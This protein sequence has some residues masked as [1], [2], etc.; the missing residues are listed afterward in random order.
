M[1]T[2]SEKYFRIF[3]FDIIAAHAAVYEFDNVIFD[4]ANDKTLHIII[5]EDK[6]KCST[7]SS[8]FLDMI[9]LFET[10]PGSIW[11]IL[12][13]IADKDAFRTEQSS[14]VFPMP[15]ITI[16]D[17]CDIGYSFNYLDILLGEIANL[18]KI[19][20]LFSSPFM[21]KNFKE[22]FQGYRNVIKTLGQT[23]PNLQNQI[24]QALEYRFVFL[25]NLLLL[26]DIKKLEK[27]YNI[28][29]ELGNDTKIE[30]SFK[31]IYMEEIRGFSQEKESFLKNIKK[32][33][34]VCGIN[35]DIKFFIKNVIPKIRAFILDIVEGLREITIICTAAE[36]SR[37]PALILIEDIARSMISK[38]KNIN[39][40]R[41]EIKKSAHCEVVNEYLVHLREEISQELNTAILVC[42]E[43]PKKVA[44]K[45]IDEFASHHPILVLLSKIGPREQK[46]DGPKINVTTEIVWVNSK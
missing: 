1:P 32:L 31:S 23:L 45:I 21:A 39:I 15:K 42:R 8:D 43:I 5:I 44:I 25:K 36:D 28:I 41:R 11:F 34:I 27:S 26:G 38:N 12:R 16:S 6:E 7:A 29:S 20:I 46:E 22:L 2:F 4:I 3:Y 30:E 24:I 13:Y 10:F 40:N 9:K 35:R 33:I 17:K 37:R 14:F 18:L 19:L